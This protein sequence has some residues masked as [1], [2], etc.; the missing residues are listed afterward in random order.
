MVFPKSTVIVE[1]VGAVRKGA[2]RRH[3]S[4]VTVPYHRA[5]LEAGR[6]HEQVR[7]K[8]KACFQKFRA[9]MDDGCA[10]KRAE[11]T[12]TGSE[13][14]AETRA[15]WRHKKSELLF[16]YITDPPMYVKSSLSWNHPALRS[17]ICLTSENLP[18]VAR[19]YFS[20]HSRVLI[21]SSGKHALHEGKLAVASLQGAQLVASS[22]TRPVLSLFWTFKREHFFLN[23]HM[24]QEERTPPK[25][26]RHKISR[27]IFAS[28]D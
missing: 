26:S 8:M 6:A 19:T 16:N 12:D 25:G 1:C 10:D 2:I 24:K 7:E 23:K 22:D 14:R 13:T 5:R 9:H 3:R 28:F 20:V 27:N 11:Q 18:Q 4:W 15:S 21:V 17:T